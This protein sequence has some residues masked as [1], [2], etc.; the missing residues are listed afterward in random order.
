MDG[1]LVDFVAGFNKR[2]GEL[3]I[4]IEPIPYEEITNYWFVE[5]QYNQRVRGVLLEMMSWPRF[6]SRMP[7]IGGAED[8]FNDLVELIG[9]RH[10]WIATTPLSRS[11]TCIQEKRDW[12]EEHLGTIYVDRM[13]FAADKTL[14][15]GD[16][17]IDDKPDISGVMW[18]TWT[19]VVY[20]HPYNRHVSLPRMTWG[21][22]SALEQHLAKFMS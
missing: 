22:T 12:V 6:F 19:Q 21:D 8:G 10:V 9:V 4:G 2:L 16:I 11:E 13:I 20:D 3:G 14:L 18:P 17:L 15:R 1:V 5:R 7:L